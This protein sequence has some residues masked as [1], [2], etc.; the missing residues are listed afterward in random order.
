MVENE[1]LMSNEENNKMAQ[2]NE[3]ANTENAGEGDQNVSELFSTFLPYN[4]MHFA[5]STCTNYITF[6]SNFILP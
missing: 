1:I 6:S 4:L 2:P 3:V 5:Y